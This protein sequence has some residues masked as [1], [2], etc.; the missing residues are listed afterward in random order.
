MQF[1]LSQK[2]LLTP[3]AIMLELESKI[4]ASSGAAQFEFTADGKKLKLSTADSES[5]YVKQIASD[6]DGDITFMLQPK[7]LSAIVNSFAGAKLVFKAV[8]QGG[9]VS[10]VEI[11][12]GTFHFSLPTVNPEAVSTLE[13]NE[14]EAQFSLSAGTLKKIVNKIKFCIVDQRVRLNLGGF[15]LAIN[16][17]KLSFVGSDS[18][19]ISIYNEDPHLTNRADISKIIPRRALLIIAKIIDEL[20]PAEQIKI[21]MDN[22]NFIIWSDN[23]LFRSVLIN[24]EY[25]NI[26][27]FSELNHEKQLLVNRRELQEALKVFRSNTEIGQG[28]LRLDISQGQLKLSYSSEEGNADSTIKIDYQGEP[29]DIT[30]NVQFL[31]EAVASFDDSLEAEIIIAFKDEVSPV[32]LSALDLPNYRHILMPLRS[33]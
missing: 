14:R 11:T 30:F 15:N 19:R 2:D 13:K 25:P 12:V 28:Q 8:R 3:L 6:G 18:F 7:R 20:D 27:R 29:R 16:D 24:D 26:K 31:N 5:S 1:S 17:G 21:D 10:R 9:D 23:F 22:N 4:I 32:I 33:N